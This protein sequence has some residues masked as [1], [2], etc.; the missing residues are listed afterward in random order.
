MF[1]GDQTSLVRKESQRLMERP[2]PDDCIESYLHKAEKHKQKDVH[3]PAQRSVR[4][5]TGRA[6]DEQTT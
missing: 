5:A 2:L 3:Q 1:A 4:Q 6:A